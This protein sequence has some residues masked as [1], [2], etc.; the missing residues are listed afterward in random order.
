MTDKPSQKS[1]TRVIGICGSLREGSYTRRIIQIAL[2]GAAAAGAQVEI[3]DLR[4]YKLVFFGDQD[5]DDY[6][7]DV[8]KLR[9]TVRDSHGIILGTPEYHGS[10]SGVLKNALDLMGF[11][12]FEGKM[13]GLV[14]VSGGRMGAV[15]IV[16]AKTA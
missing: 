11:A 2:E 10:L 15:N 6:P 14:G 1:P 3:V 5:E 7:E 8:F 13:I 16:I 4:D 12:E 9:Q